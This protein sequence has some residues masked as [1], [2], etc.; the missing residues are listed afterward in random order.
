M[1]KLEWQ[2]G[3]EEWQ[4][5]SLKPFV[6]ESEDETFPTV[7]KLRKRRGVNN[8]KR[9]R[10]FLEKVEGEPL[11]EL[12]SVGQ[13]VSECNLKREESEVLQTCQETLCDEE[14][15]E[16]ATTAVE[17]TTT[18]QLSLTEEAQENISVAKEATE[19]VA[20]EESQEPTSVTRDP[21]SQL[22]YTSVN[23]HTLW[24]R[25]WTAWEKR[26]K[27][28]SLSRFVPPGFVTDSLPDLKVRNNF[29]H[30]SLL[31]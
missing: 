21:S 10:H 17:A 31:R 1:V 7:I 26:N 2:V 16:V 22:P 29:V 13:T 4:P 25:L 18:A 23:R 27:Q 15:S 5:P 12:V 9:K 8:R 24:Q 19:H 28:F 30:G 3:L 6:V 14:E 20:M 11:Q